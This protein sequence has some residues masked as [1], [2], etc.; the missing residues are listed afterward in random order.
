MARCC[1]RHHHQKSNKYIPP[2][3][4]TDRPSHL[5]VLSNPSLSLYGTIPPPWLLKTEICARG[6]ATCQA[7]APK[8]VMLG[9]SKMATSERWHHERAPHLV[10]FLGWPPSP[11]TQWVDNQP[12]DPRVQD[13]LLKR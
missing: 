9:S 6:E 11:P 13:S 4:P 2:E 12:T 1:D 7:P 5:S 10:Q 3:A 8:V